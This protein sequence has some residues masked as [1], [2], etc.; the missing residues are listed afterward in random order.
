M[1]MAIDA[2][3]KAYQN[4]YE[5]GMFMMGD[6]DFI[7]LIEAVKNAGKKTVCIY[8][9][10]NTSKD[11]VRVFDMRISFDEKAIKSWLKE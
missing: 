8:H 9:P 2:L 7:P 11:L 3:T 1:L 4:H 6:R 5:T 10:P